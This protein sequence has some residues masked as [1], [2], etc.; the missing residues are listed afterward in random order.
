MRYVKRL[1]IQLYEIAAFAIIACTVVSRL[2]LA[3]NNWPVSDS[4]E[5]TFGIEAMHIAFRGEHP[6]YMYGQNYIGVIEAYL[7]AFYFHLFGASLF[8]LRL[9]MITIFTLFLIAIYF[10]ARFLYTKVFAIVALFLIC[11]GNDT[12]IQ[13]QLK[14]VGGGV[15][16]LLFGTLALLLASWLAFTAGQQARQQKRWR[17]LLAYVTWGLVVGL[18]LW[19]HIL[20]APF[21]LAGGLILLVFCWREW[22]TWAIPCI[23]VGLIAGG[24]PLIYYNLTVP[25]S[26]NSLAVAFS[27]QGGND[28]WA[29]VVVGHTRILTTYRGNLSLCAASCHRFDRHM[30]FERVAFLWEGW[31]RYFAVF[32]QPG[33]LS[34][35]YMS[36]L[37]IGMV[38]AIVPLRHLF[39]EYRSR[40]EIWTEEQRQA[41]VVHFARLMLLFSGLLTILFYLASNLTAVKPWS[42]RYLIAL[43]IVLPAIIWPLWNGVRSRFAI[44]RW[45]PLSLIIRYALLLLFGV[46]LLGGTVM[47]FQEIPAALAAHQNDMLLIHDLEQRGIDRFYSEYW[48]CYRLVFVSREQLIC[49]VVETNFKLAPLN[50]L[51]SYEPIVAGDPKAAYVFPPDPF[52][53]AAEHD[54]TISKHYHRFMLDGYVVFVPD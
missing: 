46:I 31:P 15:E 45:Q 41:A 52:A 37:L 6:I 21:V 3:A 25:F 42:V 13:R 24:F 44:P 1:R 51:P 33:R 5:G 11:L 30:Q 35:L 22:R 2:V 12:I 10:L 7:G 49:S 39:N 50:R 29:G 53:Q 32:S 4:D 40:R 34:L 48:T 47:T 23:L 16:T 9:G 8:T 19:S 17:R 20:V 28:P 43:S 54:P 14:A 36:L 38:M 27:I 18:G 26:Q